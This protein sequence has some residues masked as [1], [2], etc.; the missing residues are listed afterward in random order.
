MQRRR[1][2][3]PNLKIY[4]NRQKG[5]KRRRRSPRALVSLRLNDLCGLFRRRY[6]ITLP[7]DDAGRDDV[8]IAVNHLAGLP[9]PDVAIRN[10]V[11]VWAP[12]MG[13][14]ETD[15]IIV[16]TVGKRVVWTADEL[17]ARLRLTAEERKMLGITTIGAF[18]VTRADRMKQRKAYQREHKARARRA[19]GA[20]PRS[21]SVTARRPWVEA[22]ISR[23]SWYRQQQRQPETVSASA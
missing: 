21:E 11:E 5:K 1:R 10:W 7:D 4:S 14:E 3:S 23:A 13:A 12:W 9:I 18:D 17:G 22:G 6:G 2:L 8:F 16:A 20:K 15:A 19:K